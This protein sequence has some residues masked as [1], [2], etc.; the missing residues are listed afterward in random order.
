MSLSLVLFVAAILV[1]P[2]L[3]CILTGRT[4]AQTW[5]ER[6][7]DAVVV[8]LLGLLFLALWP[9]KSLLKRWLY[10]TPGAPAR[11]ASALRWFVAGIWLVMTLGAMAF[12]TPQ[13]FFLLTDRATAAGFTNLARDA[14]SMVLATVPQIL[15]TVPYTV[16]FWRRL[17]A[18]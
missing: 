3:L 8:E 12:L 16:V 10:G 14:G 1:G 15:A 2:H 5:A 6:I 4:V 9:L 13:L 18:Q 7:F 17:R 11:A